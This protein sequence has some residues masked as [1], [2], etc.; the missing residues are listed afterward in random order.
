MELKMKI[1]SKCNLGHRSFELK[2]Q[3][4]KIFKSFDVRV[5]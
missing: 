1:S 3:T 4:H 5:F 2:L